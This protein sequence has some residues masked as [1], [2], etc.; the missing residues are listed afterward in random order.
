MSYDTVITL[1][2]AKEYLRID[3]TLTQDDNQITGMIN[4]SLAFVEKWTSIYVFERN[5]EFV[6]VDGFIRSYAYPIESVISPIDITI[7]KKTLYMNFYSGHETIDLVLNVGYADPNDV[8][9]ELKSV[10][11]EIIDLLYYSH[12]T[13]KTVKK[14]LSM[15]SIDMLNQYKRFLI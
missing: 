1:A 7:Q 2:E 15:L 10:A 13:G 3:D 6:M 12:E 9:D 8:P 5:E 14:D 11:Y 4:S